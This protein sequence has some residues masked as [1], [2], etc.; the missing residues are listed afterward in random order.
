[1]SEHLLAAQTAPTA[2]EREDPVLSVENLCVYYETSAGP[3]K[4]VEDAT[5]TLRAG[6]RLALVGESGSGKTTLATALLKLTKEPGRIAGGRI[7]LD[8]RELTHLTEK[9][10]RK[11]RLADIAYVP[12]GAMNSLNPVL[13]CGDQIIDGIRAH[14]TSRSKKELARHVDRQLESVNLDASVARLYPH[15]LSGGMKQRLAM[16]ISTAL[17]PKVIV[18]DEPTSALDVVVQRQI[19]TTLGSLQEGLGAA[20]VLI[21][22]DMGLVAQFADLVGVMYAGRIVELAPVGELFQAPRHPY[23]RLLIDSLPDLEERRRLTGIPGLPPSLIGLPDACAFT[24]RC[25]YAFDRCEHESPQTQQLQPRHEVQCHLYPEHDRLPALPEDAELVE[26]HHV[27]RDLID[28]ASAV[29]AG[30]N[31]TAQERGQE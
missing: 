19:M 27:P 21:G 31:A 14:D 15:E 1:M 8:G 11:V 4:A 23:T 16:A 3:V 25:P 18:A 28:Q 29:A 5:F 7:V 30:G 20:V 22:H 12:Q 17:S 13:R 10:M 26:S 24:A 9:Q 2:D 6:E